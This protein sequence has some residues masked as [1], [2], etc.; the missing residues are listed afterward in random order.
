MVRLSASFARVLGASTLAIGLLGSAMTLPAFAQAE[1]ADTDVLMTIDGDAVTRADVE[2]ASE[3]LAEVLQR[4]PENVREEYVLT[5]LTDL[6]LIAKSDR[7]TD[8][9]DDPDVQ[10]AIEYGR[11]KALIDRVLTRVADEAAT[12]EAV[13]A[14]FD[15]LIAD[16]EP[17]EEVSAR[18]ILVETEEE[19]I[20]LKEQLDGGADF[21]ELAMEHSLDPGSGQRG[22]DLGYFGRGQMV[23][24]F[25]EAAFSLEIG[26]VSDPV[27]SQFGWHL[28]L[29]EDR[30]EKPLPTLEQVAPQIRDEIAREAARGFI[31]DLRAAAT[32]ERAGGDDA[33][34]ADDDSDEGSATE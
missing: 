18:H 10:R 23:Q 27:Q 17:E 24:P 7:A 5:F 8:M 12:D 20:A 29:V 31:E 25:D 6:E 34:A 33:E 19:A 21:A 32:I 16:A 15:E 3:D 14:R 11:K 1:Q 22:G 9:M 30:R 2:I 13:A 4:L 28:I 26:T